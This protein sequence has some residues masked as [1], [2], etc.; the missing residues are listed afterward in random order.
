MLGLRAR[1]QKRATHSA[2]RIGLMGCVLAVAVL[3][4]SA[5]AGAV[6][7]APAPPAEAPAAPPAEAPAAPAEALAATV[8]VVQEEELGT[9]LVDSKGMSLYLFLK[10][11][12]GKSN[13]YETCAQNWPPLLVEGAPGAGEGVDAA[14]LGTTTREDGTVQVTYNGWPLYYFAGDSAPG[15]TNG[16]DRGEV[17]YVLSPEGEA[18]HEK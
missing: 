16:Q 14:L 12:P 7:Y 9:Y 3:I 10:D 6:P 4:L 1:D 15:D 2:T 13:C 8:M 5:C 11:E 17:W 18:I